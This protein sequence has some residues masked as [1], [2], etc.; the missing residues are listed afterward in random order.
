MHNIEVLDSSRPG[1][2]KNNIVVM[3]ISL[4]FL[5][6]ILYPTSIGGVINRNLTM[7][8]AVI[9]ML[10]FALLI[11]IF[12]NINKLFL[13]SLLIINFILWFATLMNNGV[14]IERSVAIFFLLVTFMYCLNLKQLKLSKNVLKIFNLVNFILI[15]IGF[16][17]IFGNVPIG[18]MLINYY[19]DFYPELV[20]NMVERGKPVISFGTHS[21]AAFYMFLFFF[22]NFKTYQT[23]NKKIYFLISLVYLYFCLELKSN[24]GLFLLIFGILILFYSIKN[25]GIFLLKAL[26]PLIATVLLFHEEINNFWLNLQAEII[27]TAS[28]QDNGFLGRYVG[29]I[30]SKNLEFILNNPFNAI[31]FSS[32]SSDFVL[33]DSGLVSTAIRGTIILSVIMY[34]TLFLFFKKNL[35]NKRMAVFMFFI[36]FIFETG[37]NN[38]YYFRTIMLLP[39]III[40][41]NYLEEKRLKT[42]V[43]RGLNIE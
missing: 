17:M 2:R 32:N 3:L 35:I 33:F 24:T 6:G 7:L 20:P 26:L 28:S 15:T 40:F 16:F 23:L 38:L 25:K 30:Q 42:E 10:L 9:T 37:F 36:F 19:S 13:S 4:L 31:G 21:I 18:K 43:S 12:K 34:L 5:I 27:M 41:L 1:I 8:I 29:G 11:V 39:F 22:L 14:T